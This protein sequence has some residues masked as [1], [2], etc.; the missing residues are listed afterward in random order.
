MFIILF[1]KKVPRK[2]TYQVQVTRVV[3]SGSQ[4]QKISAVWVQNLGEAKFSNEVYKDSNF[5]L[6][7]KFFPLYRNEVMDADS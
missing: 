6:N 2:S 3:P 1:V 7:K 5:K 4:W